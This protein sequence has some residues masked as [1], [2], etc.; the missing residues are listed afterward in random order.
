MPPRMKL[1]AGVEKDVLKRAFA[2]VLPIEVVQRA[3]SGM[4]I[5][6]HSWFRNELKCTAEDILST[7]AVKDAGIFDHRRVRDLRNYRTGRDGI[8]LWMLVTFELWR[9]QVVEQE[10]P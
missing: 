2:N 8:R 4:R 1:R 7:R 9:R 6:V 5:P 10:H 3:K